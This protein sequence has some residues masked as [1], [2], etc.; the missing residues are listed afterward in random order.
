MPPLR[1]PRIAPSKLIRRHTEPVSVNIKCSSGPSR[2]THPT[3]S[4]CTNQRR[5][6]IQH[7]DVYLCSNAVNAP[8]L[9]ALTRE[10]MDIQVQYQG[11]NA[12]VDELYVD[13]V[14]RCF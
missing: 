3:L 5:G 1:F 12:M 8:R 2:K 10:A 13:R 9:V 14:F 6:I 11:G 4:T 7:H